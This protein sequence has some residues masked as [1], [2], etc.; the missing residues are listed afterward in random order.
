MTAVVRPLLELINVTL[1][2][3]QFPDIILSQ[4]TSEIEILVNHLVSTMNMELVG[5]N[6][7]FKAMHASE[8]IVVDHWRVKIEDVSRHLRIQGSW[9]HDMF[10]GLDATDQTLILKEIAHFKLKLVQGILVIQAKR[11][12][13]NKA[14]LDLAPP[15]MSFKL[16]E[17]A[18]CNFI[19]SLLDPYGSQLAKLWPNEKIDF[20]KQHQQELFYAYK[21]EPN[22]KL[23][24]DKHDHTTFFN[25]GWD[26]LKGRFEHLRMF[27]SGLAN[28]FANATSIELDFNILKWEK[29]D[30]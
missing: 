29:G 6:D 16:V 23:L 8:F 28:A 2:I 9:A 5:I 27:C 7:A 30:F 17:M 19:N 14:T 15:V 26:D 4:Q 1:V 20:I 22:S 11:D 24:I 21:R 12:S 3:L 13:N 10:L 18:P 25:M